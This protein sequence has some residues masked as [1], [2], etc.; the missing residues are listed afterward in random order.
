MIGLLKYVELL[1]GLLLIL[2]SFVELLLG[3]SKPSLGL[4][5]IEKAS[6]W[7]SFFADAKKKKV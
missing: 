5:N 7:S 6:P 4:G 1:V 2:I 3:K